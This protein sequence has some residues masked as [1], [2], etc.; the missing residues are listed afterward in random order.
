MRCPL[1]RLIFASRVPAVV[2]RWIAVVLLVGAA[3]QSQGSDMPHLDTG[4]PQPPRVLKSDERLGARDPGSAGVTLALPVA[5]EVVYVDPERASASLLV[6][7]GVVEAPSDAVISGRRMVVIGT[8]TGTVAVFDLASGKVLRRRSLATEF[9]ESPVAWRLVKGPS[10]IYVLADLPSD[11]A[12]G[13]LDPS[14]LLIKRVTRV[15]LGATF[16]VRDRFGD[17]WVVGNQSRSS[18]VSIVDLPTMRARSVMLPHTPAS[19]VATRAGV[20]ATVWEQGLVW[21]LSRLGEIKD[22]ARIDSRVWGATRLADGSRVAISTSDGR[23]SDIRILHSRTL[24]TKRIIAL[25]ERCPDARE[26]VNVG[27][28]V[29]VACLG[30]PGVAIVHLRGLEPASF[31]RLDKGLEIPE[32]AH[33]EN[34][35]GLRRVPRVAVRGLLDNAAG[36][37]K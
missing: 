20:V 28:R 3:C 7:T 6:D 32:E 22:E 21:R 16:G 8:G 31:V 35:R 34:P 17:L 12:V 18:P 27:E 29:V 36:V 19:L 26:V 11:G 9:G 5:D 13:L 24:R 33:I 4:G 1:L 15:G 10:G 25:G 30:L 14:T 37:K 23:R 2:R